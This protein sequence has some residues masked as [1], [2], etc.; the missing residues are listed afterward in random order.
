MGGARDESSLASAEISLGYPQS[1]PTKHGL[2]R[3]VEKQDHRR[4][5]EQDPPL[6][7]R[8]RRQ[9]ED[10]AQRGSEDQ[11]KQ[12]RDLH[13]DADEH[14]PI[15]AQ[16]DTEHRLALGAAREHVSDLG[17]DDRRE[18]H[19]GGSPI[20]LARTIHRKSWPP[21]GDPVRPEEG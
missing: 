18:R 10:A 7:R 19:R 9:A 5:Q 6:E 13:R 1:G 16:A 17:C 2:T 20:E 4:K 21:P 12:Y 14:H 15:R 8:E 11:A 3:L